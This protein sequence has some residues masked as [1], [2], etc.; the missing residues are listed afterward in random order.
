MKII[1]TTVNAKTRKLNAT[2]TVEKSQDLEHHISDELAR[3]LQE[4]IEKEI[5]EEITG[6]TLVEQGWTKVPITVWQNV[7]MDRWLEENMTNEYK[8]LKKYAYF[9]S[10]A[11]A[12]LY[13]LKWASDETT[14]SF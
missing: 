8:H 14:R 6:N 13:I 7:D 3:I 4:E 11:D 2:W 10:S 5:V 1:K 12:T 9:K